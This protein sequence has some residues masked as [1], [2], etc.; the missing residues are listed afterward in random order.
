MNKIKLIYVIFIGLLIMSSCSN[1]D[2]SD[3]NLEPEPVVFTSEIIGV[4]KPMKSVIVCSTGSEDAYELDPCEKRG[5]IIFS[6]NGSMSI[7]VNE[8]Y[9]DMCG[10][11]YQANGTWVI[12]NNELSLTIDGET[13]TPA[14]FEL[15]SSKLRIG[16]ND[17]EE[18]ERCDGDNLPSHYY[19]EYERAE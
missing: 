18:G 17:F 10:R 12:I 5:E 1:N 3:S 8:A 4:W 2:E 11:I 16:D 19:I 7:S 6:E 15:N 9:T 13:E 14:F